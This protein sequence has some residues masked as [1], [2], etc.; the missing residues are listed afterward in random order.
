MLI[1]NYAA[2]AAADKLITEFIFFILYSKFQKN[3]SD[4]I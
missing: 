3:I 1:L 4:L 2:A